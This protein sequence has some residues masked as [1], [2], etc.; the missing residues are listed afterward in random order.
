[1]R[2][3]G[4][5]EAVGGRAADRVAGRAATRQEEPKSLPS[6]SAPRL[7]GILPAR[8]ILSRVRP[9]EK[10][11]NHVRPA[12]IFGA[13]PLV[14]PRRVPRNPQPA[15]SPRDPFHLPTDPR[16]PQPRSNVP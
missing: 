1:M 8:K 7:P 3:I 4:T 2:E 9:H 13:L 15:C 11:H 14:D 12:P 5:G 6:L 10:P 16:L